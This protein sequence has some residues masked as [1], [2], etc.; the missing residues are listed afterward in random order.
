MTTKEWV[1]LLSRMADCAHSAQSGGLDWMACDL[2]DLV[3][4]GLDEWF[5]RIVEGEESDT[6]S[7][8]NQ[9][10]VPAS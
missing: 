2:N 3:R 9:S 7:E 8:G 1:R 4:A 5:A 6:V 10:G